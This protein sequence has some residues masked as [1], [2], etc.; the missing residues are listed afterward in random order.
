[1]CFKHTEDFYQFD[2]IKK[3]LS[4][5]LDILYL[6][7]Y[8]MAN[9]I[10]VGGFM[11]ILINNTSK[12][13]VYQQIAVQIRQSMLKGELSEG[14]ALP[15]VRSLS[16]DLGVSVITIKKAYDLLEDQGLVVTQAGRGTFVLEK[17][18]D[19]VRD[20]KL[21]EIQ[22]ILAKAIDT[23]KSSGIK[24][25]DVQEIFSLLWEENHAGN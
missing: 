13:P 11:T 23:A 9:E 19:L 4:N 8:I 6:L 7:L 12:T 25:D 20:F 22:D 21:K 5:L 1:M 3:T 2:L 15:S 18:L 16:S 10:T 17:N 24:Q 14:E